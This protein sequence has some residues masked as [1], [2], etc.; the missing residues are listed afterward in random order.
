MAVILEV[1]TEV[2]AYARMTHGNYVPFERT[3]GFT[4]TE[5]QT[6]GEGDLIELVAK[7]MMHHYIAGQNGRRVSMELTCGAGDDRDLTVWRVHTKNGWTKCDINVK[8]SRYR[9]FRDGLNLI[10]KQ[11]ELKRPCDLYVQCFVHLDE[12]GE[13]PHMHIA[14]FSG[15]TCRVWRE[16]KEVFEIRE[17]GGHEGMQIP[18]EKLLPFEKFVQILQ[19]R[20]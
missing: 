6:R 13:S 20:F 11:E 7:L 9:P 15:P 2:L 18:V 10:I 5:A 17:T 3:A 8:T 4:E 12:Y 1:P 14:G 19:K 16:H